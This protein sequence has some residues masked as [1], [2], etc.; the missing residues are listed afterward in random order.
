MSDELPALP[1]ERSRRKAGPAR[2]PLSRD[3]IVDAAYAVLDRE[4]YDKLSMRQV[5]SELGVAVSALYVHVASKDEL[6]E[7]MYSRM[8]DDWVLPDP[9]PERWQEQV[10]EYARIWRAK[11]R[12]HRDLAKISMNGVPFAPEMLPHLN[13]ALGIFRAGGLPDHVA[14]AAGDVISTFIDGFTLEE[15][16]WDDRRR[17]AGEGS[18]ENMKEALQRYFSELPPE[19]FPHLVALSGALIGD[20][21]DERFALGI[22]IIT[23]GLASFAEDAQPHPADPAGSKIDQTSSER[24]RPAKDPKD[25]T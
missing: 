16:L 22:E 11:L 15:D 10:M 3:R 2:I 19:R 18:W 9:D 13:Q 8:F 21:N 25:A 12:T 23:R 24:P 5:A 4:G 6:L 14:A 1:W 17:K 20:A 7:L